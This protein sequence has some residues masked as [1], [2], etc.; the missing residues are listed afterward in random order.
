MEH[1]LDEKMSIDVADMPQMRQE[2][3]AMFG[4]GRVIEA[5]LDKLIEVAVAK[6]AAEEAAAEAATD[7]AKQL[8][9]AE[10]EEPETKADDKVE[11][12]PPNTLEKNTVS[13]C[14][15]MT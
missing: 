10:R 15:S 11:K 2:I 9:P 8:F 14:T 1:Y 5:Y 3:L 6:L 13:C 12:Q 4:N 7:P